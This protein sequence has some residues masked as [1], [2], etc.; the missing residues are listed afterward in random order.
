[1]NIPHKASM[2][3]IAGAAFV[4]MLLAGAPLAAGTET[5]APSPLIDAK[6]YLITHTPVA[7][8]LQRNLQ[9][10]PAG[11]TVDP[12]LMALLN[13]FPDIFGK[14]IWDEKSGTLTINYYTGA[15][16]SQEAAFLE[17]TRRIDAIVPPQ[18]QLVWKPVEW[19][20]KARFNLLQEITANPDKWT[21][22]FGSAPQSGYVEIDGN[23]HVSL[24]DPSK[25][26]SAP[27]KLGILPDGTPFVADQ[28]SEAQWQVGRTN[29][30][31]PWTGG[32]LLTGNS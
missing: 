32:D 21:S 28:P 5:P 1:M 13:E 18:L 7:W 4:A 9:P 29:D 24:A 31:T 22:Y 20:N 2:A 30:I 14:S 11:R 6:A 23:V 10:S 8:T 3:V 25:V 27:A 17:A 19:N 15:E 12:A 26:S 16:P